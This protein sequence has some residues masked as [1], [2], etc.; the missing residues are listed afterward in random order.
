MSSAIFAYAR[1]IYNYRG[2]ILESAKREIEEKYT[3]SVLGAFWI[4]INPVATIFIYTII[5]SN[6]M[7]NRIEGIDSHYSYSIYLCAGILTWGL[8]AEI[9]SRSQTVFIENAAII[10]KVNFPKIILPALVVTRGAVNFVIIFGVFTLFLILFGSFPGIVFLAMVP[11]LVIQMLFAIGIGMTL[12]VLNVFFRDVGQFYGVI[13]QFWFWLTPIVY[14]VDVLPEAFRTYLA[15]NPMLPLVTGYQDIL[16]RGQWP[17]WASV[18]P[19]AMIA[20]LICV[21]GILL[22]RRRSGEMVD[23]L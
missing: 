15:W 11:L 5:F 3:N 6:L 7:R 19:T 12:G 20:L 17:Q 14:P 10:K 16:V 2:F 22:F 8:F 21:G 9:T 4:F 1:N 23:E 18:W 13:L